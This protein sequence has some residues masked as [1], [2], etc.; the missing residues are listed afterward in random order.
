MPTVEEGLRSQLRNIETSTG[1][2]I[3]DWVALIHASGRAKHGEIVAWLKTDYGL[4]HG[5][6][7]RLAVT[8]LNPVSA[9]DPATATGAA[10]PDSVES[11]YAGAKSA[12]R[13]IHDR[14]MA[15]IDGFGAPI[16]VAPKKGYLSLRRRTQF[17]M[18]K[19]AAKQLDLGLILPGVAVTPRLESAAT[20]NALFTHR[21]RLVSV[22]DVDDQL[23]DWLHTAWE[24]AG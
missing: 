2:S 1:R 13:P 17:A 5:T 7:N 4:S 12:L 6:A 14:V 15:V 3:P 16:D 18:L 22:A 10:Q 19:P 9:A 8:A 24:R 11:L 20:F 23:T 21:V